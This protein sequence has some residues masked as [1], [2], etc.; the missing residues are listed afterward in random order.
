MSDNPLAAPSAA[1]EP[2]ALPASEA[3]SAPERAATVQPAPT[4]ATSPTPQAETPVLSA[5]ERYARL[6]EDQDVWVLIEADRQREGD[7]LAQ[8]RLAREQRRQAA[9]RVDQVLAAED[10]DPDEAKQALKDL[11]PLLEPDEPSDDELPPHQRRA[12]REQEAAARPM[13]QRLTGTSNAD[14]YAQVYAQH[15]QAEMNRRYLA[16]PAAFAD[17]LLNRYVDLRAEQKSRKVAPVLAEALATDR[18]AEALRNAP[19]PPTLGSGGANDDNDAF[20]Q[21]HAAGES[22]DHARAMRLLGLRL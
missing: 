22:N 1:P 4:T 17:W 2:S 12:W 7:R 15:G 5:A 9:R 6:R 13:L 18:T 20:I 21:R 16:D 8:K 11:R 19:A 14:L 10:T 3:D